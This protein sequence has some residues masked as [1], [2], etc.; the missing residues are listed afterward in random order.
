LKAHFALKPRLISFH[1]H[2]EQKRIPQ[3]LSRIERGKTFAL[4]SDAGAPLVSDPGFALV[5]ELISRRVPF[6]CVPGPSAVIT[7]LLLSGFP[8]QPFIF[9]GF[10]P[11]KTAERKREMQALQHLHGHTLILFESPERVVSLVREIGELLGDRAI[12]IC[13]EMTKLHEEVLRGRPSELLPQIVGRKLIGEFTIVVAPG[14]EPVS[15]MS[16]DSIRARFEQ[17]LKEGFNRKDALKKISKE[18]GRSRNNL[19]NLLIK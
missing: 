4:I 1:E 3:I 14:E 6:T 5:R 10:L 7:A 19:Y 8:P 12:A 13:R 9:C 16:D 17:L 2:N 15:R 18:S 11:I